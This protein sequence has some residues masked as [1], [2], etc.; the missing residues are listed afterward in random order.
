M[1]IAD[2][3][4]HIYPCYDVAKALA[5]LFDNMGKIDPEGVKA[6]FLAERFDCNFFRQLADG[7]ISTG[8][9]SVKK[10]HGDNVLLLQRNGETVWLFAGR[11]VISVERIEVLALA[12]DAGFDDGISLEDAVEMISSRGGVPVLPWSP[13]KWF[14]GRGRKV[15]ALLDKRQ[16]GQLLVGDTSLRPVLWGKPRLMAYAERKGY[17]IIAGSDPLPFAGE[18]SVPGSY[19]S[20]IESDLDCQQPVS[21]MRK[22]LLSTENN[23]TVV[24]RRNGVCSAL[25]RQIM[26]RLAR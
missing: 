12:I 3:H 6:A 22:I 21:S 16:P 10:D 19:V 17:S 25:R 14:S 1:I 13:G 11:Q 26:N 7:K 15:K 23:L 4:L 24:G 2:T 18:E 9:I 8:D 20:V 5:G